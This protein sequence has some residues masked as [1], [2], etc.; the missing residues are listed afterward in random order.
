MNINWN[1][2]MFTA[3]EQVSRLKAKQFAHLFSYILIW[4]IFEKNDMQNL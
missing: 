1:Y 2:N 3:R 4:K